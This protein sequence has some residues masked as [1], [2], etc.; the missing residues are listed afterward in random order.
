MDNNVQPLNP[1]LKITLSYF[2]INFNSRL[3]P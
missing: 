3:Q 1:S 2:A